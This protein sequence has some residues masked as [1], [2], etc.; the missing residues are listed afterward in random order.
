MVGIL[1]HQLS[2][3]RDYVPCQYGEADF[4]AHEKSVQMLD[5]GVDC[6]DMIPLDEAELA[7]SV[8]RSSLRSD[9][10]W[11]LWDLTWAWVN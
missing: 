1:A 5:G 11:T 4:E 3:Q 8:S 9:S 10:N 6:G 7:Y 2:W